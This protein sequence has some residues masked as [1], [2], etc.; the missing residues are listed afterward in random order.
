MPIFCSQP[1]ILVGSPTADHYQYRC[2]FA[3]YPKA[4]W[5]GVRRTRLTD[6]IS[7]FLGPANT[8]RPENAP[9]GQRRGGVGGLKRE[10]VPVR[11]LNLLNLKRKFKS[12]TFHPSQSSRL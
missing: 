10:Q 7:P 9:S 3:E 11:A 6:A 5:E 2:Q 12:E 4:S 8:I 1:P